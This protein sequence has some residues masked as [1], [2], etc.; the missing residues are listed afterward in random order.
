MECS[1]CLEDINNKPK[2]K[3]SCHHELHYQCFLSYLIKSN[4]SI[5]ISC[6][7]CRQMNTNNERPFLNE[8]DNL[9]FLSKKERCNHRLKNGKRCKNKCSLM[10]N[11]VC[12]IH[13]K[14]ILPK[15]KYKLICDFIFYS[16]ETSNTIKT[17][18]YMLD[19]A[20]KLIIKFP[21]IKTIQD[22][23]HY[24][25]EYY[26]FNNKIKNVQS[27]QG[28][29]KYYGLQPPADGWYERCITNNTIF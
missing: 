28:I 20:K 2:I 17:K 10:N 22:I 4:K 21:K 3:L 6:P 23:Q 15:T 27:I 5:F 13:N 11:G 24:F 26:H 7:L 8:E 12:Y 19:I 16:I 29:Y 1:I 9:S 18:I 14:D 25:F